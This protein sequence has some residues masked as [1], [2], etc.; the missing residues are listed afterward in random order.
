MTAKYQTDIL[1][2]TLNH[3]DPES[4]H[5]LG[6][7]AVR[8][9]LLDPNLRGYLHSWVIPQLVALRDG[10]VPKWLRD[11]VASERTSRHYVS[12]RSIRN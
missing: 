3:L 11:S 7:D 4:P 6:S 9:A 1:N 10:N 2:S 5:F 8:V 12:D